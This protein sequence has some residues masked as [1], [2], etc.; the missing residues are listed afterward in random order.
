MTFMERFRR[1]FFILLATAVLAA[2][3]AVSFRRAL[4]RG[5]GTALFVDDPIERSDAIILPQWAGR[6]G[7]IEAADLVHGGVSDR[8]VVLA[9][10]Q[11]GADEEL[12]RRGVHTNSAAQN[13]V[14]LL[15]ALGVT[16]V[17]PLSEPANGTEAEG[18]LLP[19]F[20]ETHDL[21]AIV[22]VSTSDH[23]RRIRRVLHRSMK[24]AGVNTQVRIRSARFSSFKPDGWWETRDGTR[25][26]IEELEKLILDVARHPIS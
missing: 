16:R 7:A 1:W 24:E 3:L 4:L 17:E 6:A 11:P 9:E 8:V 5:L 23:S 2:V 25:T 12:A 21:H 15:A 22:V 20:C 13:L 18:R 19:Q 26:E 14:Q 10:A